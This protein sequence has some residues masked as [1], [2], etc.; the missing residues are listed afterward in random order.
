MRSSCKGQSLG[1]SQPA[2][3]LNTAVAQTNGLVSSKCEHTKPMVK[4]ERAQKVANKAKS[5]AMQAY[6]NHRHTMISNVK[7]MIIKECG[8]NL[9]VAKM[10]VWGVAEE[11]ERMMKERKE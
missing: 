2:N 1:L 11:L 8:H 7:E 5:I 4:G 6:H 9:F 3:T 10:V